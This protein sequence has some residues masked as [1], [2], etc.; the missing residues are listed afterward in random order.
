MFGFGKVENIVVNIKCVG[1]PHL[2]FFYMCL[3]VIILHII[4]VS[5]LIKL[6]FFFFQDNVGYQFSVERSIIFSCV[7]LLVF[8]N[9]FELLDLSEGPN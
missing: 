5:L 2:I 7:T 8:D 3:R 4:V 6:L 1:S 9:I